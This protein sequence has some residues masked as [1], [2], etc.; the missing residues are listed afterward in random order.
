MPTMLKLFISYAREDE[1]IADAVRA[2]LTKALPTPLAY[3]EMDKYTIDVGADFAVDIQEKLDLAHVLVLVY[4][5]RPKLS[6]GYTGQELGYFR[7][8]IKITPTL[9]KIPRRIAFVSL[10]EP[11]PSTATLNGVRIAISPQDLDRPQD[12]YRQ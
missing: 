1:K 5:A 12:E 11:P 7:S 9:D 2:A 8:Q 6:F 3:V 4:T 10:G